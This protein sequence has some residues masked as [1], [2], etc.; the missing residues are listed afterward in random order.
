MKATDLLKRD[1][2]A[3][4]RLFTQFGK[5]TTRAHKT[6]AKLIEKISM[7]LEVHARIEEEIFYP[8]MQRVEQARDL[9]REA[10]DEH[11]DV[12]ELVREIS[13]ME[14][15]SKELPARMRELR[16]AMVHHAS[17]EE[18]EM[19][20][21]A[22]HQLGSEELERLGAELEQRK[23]SLMPAEPSRGH[24]RRKAA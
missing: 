10:K 14:P 9:V 11:A 22:E 1:H 5:T 7:E 17:E 21:I 3:T 2:T 16:E 8:A 13:G 23:Q 6:R 15:S 24:K 4:K 19:F 12:K 20:P 18:K